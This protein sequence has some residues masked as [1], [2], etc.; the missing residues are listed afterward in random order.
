[1][2]EFTRKQYEQNNKIRML[3]SKIELLEK[4]L[5]EIV[6]N[7]EKEKELLRF[8]SEQV[9]KEQSEEVRG[10]R[11]SIRLKT[12]EVKNLKAL[13]Q[14]ILDQ[15]S[16]I[17]QFFLEA[18]EQVKEEK[19][20]KLAASSA[21]QANQQQFLP[22]IDPKSKFSKSSYEKQQ[23][24]QISEKAAAG[25]VGLSSLDWEDRERILRLMFSKMNSGQAPTNWRV[26]DGAAPTSK[27]RGSSNAGTTRGDLNRSFRV[28]GEQEEEEEDDGYDQEIDEDNEEDE[29]D[30]RT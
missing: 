16:D 15:R 6:S 29:E 5:S 30:D 4:R 23:Q 1:M 25:E 20:R 24:S 26:I 27:G 28:T 19:R 2:E 17:E 21:G 11:E 10:L 18:L 8:Q 12:R 7:F 13:C 14:M 22:L 9:I 3:K